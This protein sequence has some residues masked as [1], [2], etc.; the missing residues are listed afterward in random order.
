MPGFFFSL[1]NV[2]TRQNTLIKTLVI[3]IKKKKKKVVLFYSTC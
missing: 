2:I 1:I 3:N